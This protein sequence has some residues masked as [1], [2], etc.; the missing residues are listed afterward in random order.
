LDGVAASEP[1]AA[2]PVQ[3][4]TP[5]AAMPSNRTEAPEV[6]EARRMVRARTARRRRDGL[7]ANIV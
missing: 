1:H 6:I 3:A 2:A 4:A 7:V 5:A